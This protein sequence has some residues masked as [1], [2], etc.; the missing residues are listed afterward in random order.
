M[1]LDSDN[2]LNSVV[3]DQLNSLDDTD[4][5][6]SAWAD[7]LISAKESGKIVSWGGRGKGGRGIARKTYQPHT[8]VVD[9]VRLEY[10]SGTGAPSKVLLEGATLKLLSNRVYAFIGRNG[11]GKSTLLRRIDAGKIPGFPPHLSSFYVPQEVLPVETQ[12]PLDIVLSHHSV[13]FQRSKEATQARITQL[14]DEL[15]ELDPEEQTEAMEEL[16]E[17]IADLEEE[18]EGRSHDAEMVRRQAEESLS[19]FGINESLWNTP[20]NELSGGQRKVLC[21]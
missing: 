4:C 2:N 20:S 19:F 12:T 1:R 9:D 5:Y 17:K 15:E 7:A 6:A 13:L 14:E 16:C 8:V 18:L 10:V 3:K 21:G 11:C